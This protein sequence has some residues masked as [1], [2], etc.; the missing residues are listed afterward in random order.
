MNAIRQ[1]LWPTVTN[2]V[3]AAVAVVENA[4]AAAEKRPKPPKARQAQPG[5]IKT[6][7]R[8]N[9]RTSANPM[10]QQRLMKRSQSKMWISRSAKPQPA[11]AAT[12]RSE[13]HRRGSAPQRPPQRPP[14][15]RP[16]PQRPA[17]PTPMPP[18]V[19]TGSTDRHIVDDEPIDSPP[20]S[21]PRSYR[22]LDELPDDLD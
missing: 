22:D 19:R 4:I 15:S 11:A 3:V 17:S 13:L 2:P 18:I 1:R 7:N 12:P 10:S 6:P 8:M 9:R 20:P 21:R 5:K 14:V 16:A